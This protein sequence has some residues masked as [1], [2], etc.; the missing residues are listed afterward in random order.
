MANNVY[1][2]LLDDRKP[3]DPFP[4]T[5]N[6][7]KTKNKDSPK[8]SKEMDPDLAINNRFNVNT[9][10]FSTHKI[11]DYDDNKDDEEAFV[12]FTEE[13]KKTKANIQQKHQPRSPTAFPTATCHHN[14]NKNLQ[15]NP[16]QKL[17]LAKKNTITSDNIIASSNNQQ[18]QDH[19]QDNVDEFPF[20]RGRAYSTVKPCTLPAFRPLKSVM[21]TGDA[22][23]EWYDIF[24]KL[25]GIESKQ[26][27]AP[28]LLSTCQAAIRPAPPYN[29]NDEDDWYSDRSSNEL[30]SN[31]KQGLIEVDEPSLGN[32]QRP[33]STTN[34]IQPPPQPP[35]K[36]PDLTLPLLIQESPHAQIATSQLLVFNCPPEYF[37]VRTYQDYNERLH[38]KGTRQ[39]FYEWITCQSTDKQSV[40]CLIAQSFNTSWDMWESWVG[41]NRH[42]MQ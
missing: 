4:N 39:D 19:I 8:T 28:I 30:I 42:W 6:R 7:M 5:D 41:I 1:N 11:L 40:L 37:D 35:T 24:N 32:S 22:P 21:D 38:W 20:D 13:E 2:E 10:S 14:T 36:K 23:E 29:D 3:P 26:L 15:R 17:D 34:T 18:T 27:A 31:E 9:N 16:A 25:F 12:Y 33:C